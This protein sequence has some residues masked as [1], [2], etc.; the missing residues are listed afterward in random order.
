MFYKLF[1]IAMLGLFSLRSAHAQ[2]LDAYQKKWLVQG[3]DTLPYRLLLPVSFD[4]GKKYPVVLFL[5]GAGERGRDNEAQLTHGAR[6][7]LNDT[8]RKAFPA[9]VVFPQCPPDQYWS[10]VLRAVD[11]T[12]RRTFTFQEGGVPTRP[13]AMLANLLE[14][15]HRQYRIK[16]DQVYVMGLSMGG[17]GTFE[18]ARRHPDLFAAAVPICGGAHPAT[19]GQLKRMQWWVFHGG[20]DDVVPLQFSETM[21]AA[22]KA[23]GAAV[24]F[25]VYPEAGHNSW[26]NAFAEPG[27]LP[28]LFAQHK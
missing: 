18:L 8:I 17:M 4:A 19:A 21:A 16:G 7:F 22:L 26:D 9:I 13:M 28:W 10:N 3:P 23:Q 2:E 5:H 25:T 20:K 12:G 24:T 1:L 15:L 27:L 11:S 14:E 6:L